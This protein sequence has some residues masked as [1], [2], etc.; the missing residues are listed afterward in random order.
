M[1]GH[2]L[3][4][5]LSL[6]LSLT[7]SPGLWFTAV[8]RRRRRILCCPPPSDESDTD[9]ALLPSAIKSIAADGMESRCHAMPSND[10]SAV[11]PNPSKN[12]VFKAFK[13][14]PLQAGHPC[15]LSGCAGLVVTTAIKEKPTTAKS[16]EEDGRTG[17]RAGGRACRVAD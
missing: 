15:R 3:S 11:V 4:L 14:G 12:H 17:R 10:P 5:S 13:I 6:S 9:A 2:P 7:H 1:P 16:E 8:L